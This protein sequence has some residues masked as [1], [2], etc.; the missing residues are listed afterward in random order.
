MLLS[1]SAQRYGRRRGPKP[2]DVCRTVRGGDCREG[3]LRKALGSAQRSR[4]TFAAAKQDAWRGARPPHP[5]RADVRP[6]RRRRARPTEAGQA[7]PRSLLV[8]VFLPPEV[9]GFRSRNSRS[10]KNLAPH[11]PAFPPRRPPDGDAIGCPTQNHPATA[12]LPYPPNT[13][14]IDHA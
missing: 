5:G 7:G 1:T 6:C 13:R 14:S 11:R 4:S 12:T 8:Q 2:G 9:A 3:H 10:G